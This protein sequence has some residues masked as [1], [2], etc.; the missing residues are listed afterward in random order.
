MEEQT[1]LQRF[2]KMKLR[3]ALARKGWNV[4]DIEELRWEDI[5]FEDMPEIPR[6]FADRHCKQVPCLQKDTIE[7][8]GMPNFIFF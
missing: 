5:S 1:W 7:T 8:H 6:C 4:N 2:E 3:S